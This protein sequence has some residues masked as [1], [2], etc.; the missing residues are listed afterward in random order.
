MEWTE[1]FNGE[2]EE[3]KELVFE[4]KTKDSFLTKFQL[5]KIEDERENF[6]FDK[7]GFTPVINI[8]TREMFILTYKENLTV[9]LLKEKEKDAIKLLKKYN[10]NN[11]KNII[12]VQYS[13]FFEIKEQYS[14]IDKEYNESEAR[15]FYKD[16]LTDASRKHAS[17]IHLTWMTDFIS[18]RYRLDGILVLQPKKIDLNLGTAL[19]NIFVNLAGESEYQQNEVAGQYVEYIDNVKTEYRLSIGPTVQ[20]HVIVIRVEHKIDKNANLE[21]LG[22]SEKAI[23]MIRRLFL[24]RHGLVLVTGQ[25]GSGKSTLMYTSAVER[26]YKDP[27]RI[28]QILTVEDPV[29]MVVDGMNQV[30]VNTKGEKENWI[31]F[32]TAIKMFLRQNPDVIIVGEIRDTEVAIQAVTAAK[33]GH[34]TCSTLHTNN[35]KATFPR[36]RELGIDN[37]NIEDA[38]KG[39]ISQSLIQKLCDN[40]K[41]EEIVNGEVYY[42]R[43]K[44]GCPECAGSSSIGI[45]GRV[46]IVEIAVLN[47]NLYNY[48]PENYE[49]YYSVEE[50]I[51]FLLKA[52]KIDLQEANRIVKINT[53]DSLSRRNFVLNK[54]NIATKEKG[55]GNSDHIFPVY[56]GILDYNGYILGYETFM[57]IKD[58]NGNLIYPEEFLNLIREMDLY[59][60]FSI[61]ILDQII[62]FSKKNEK[63]I[64]WNIEIENIKDS[65]FFEVV[66]DKL[67]ENNLMNKIVLEFNYKNDQIYNDFIKK[68]NEKGILVSIDHFEGNISDLMAIERNGLK[69]SFIK[70]NKNFIEGFSHKEEWIGEYLDLC[71]KFKSSV[72][73]N[74][75]ETSNMYET[76]KEIY[77]NKVYGF[78]GYGVQMPS[79]SE[80]IK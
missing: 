55:G 44:H 11:E 62:D 56:Q 66:V 59:Y 40:C 25:T 77:K 15:N 63:K 6:I 7:Y 10:Q 50:N 52:G 72:I 36:L 51:H 3:K 69:I 23:E 41:E 12:I 29:E 76:F 57:R 78:Q 38:C 49:E 27:I 8:S 9:E 46:P 39:I 21:G 22:Y 34:L 74:F 24:E 28:P 47:N 71:Q 73:L 32:T 61:F 19:K 31:T 65:D 42:K 53:N 60:K 79:N 2:Q 48:L 16:L 13:I 4:Y 58:D 17:D 54:W 14:I 68:C 45:K 64:F 1:L 30:Q 75:I 18:I 67:M 20:G 43:S 26:L 5:I 33:T 35:V 80:D 70:T 37:S